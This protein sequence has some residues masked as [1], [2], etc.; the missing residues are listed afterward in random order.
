MSRAHAE[1]GRLTRRLTDEELD[2]L[3]LRLCEQGE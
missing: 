2:L 3:R 1:L